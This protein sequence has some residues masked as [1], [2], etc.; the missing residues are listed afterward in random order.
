MLSAIESRIPPADTLMRSFARLAC[1]FFLAAIAGATPARAQFGPDCPY[2][3]CALRVAYSPAGAALVRGTDQIV[4]NGLGF[5]ARDMTRAFE[6]NR[7]AQDLAN[8]YRERHNLGTVLTGVGAV[9][10]FIGLIGSDGDISLD[11]DTPSLLTLGGLVGI[12]VGSRVSLSAEDQLS[13]AIWEYNR[14]LP[15]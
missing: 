15:R 13:R 3:S 11:L 12:A 6:G 9:S 14:T 1:A 10:F 4:I 8:S 2:D 5:W 7:I